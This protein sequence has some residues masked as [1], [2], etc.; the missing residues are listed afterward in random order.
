M[1]NININMSVNISNACMAEIHHIS[2]N[3][4]LP[5][6]IMDL[7]PLKKKEKGAKKKR[8]RKKKKILC[9]VYVSG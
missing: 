4:A 5:L 6:P 3:N 8:E 2:R 1:C 9:P 7:A